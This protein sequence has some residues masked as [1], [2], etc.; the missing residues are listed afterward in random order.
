MIP[1]KY[2]RCKNR[3]VNTIHPCVS[4]QEHQR[5]SF[6]V[7]GKEIGNILENLYIDI[8]QNT[9][10][11]KNSSWNVLRFLDDCIL[12]TCKQSNKRKELAPGVTDYQI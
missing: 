3:I 6:F 8:K 7:N 1:K 5:I 4:Y 9:F 12:D 2:R 11:F 10:L